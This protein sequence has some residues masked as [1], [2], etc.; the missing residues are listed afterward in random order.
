MY[1]KIIVIGNLGRDPEM[2]YLP[3]GT[4]VCNFNVATS[5]NWTANGEKKS[6]TTWFK[7]AVWG[8]SAEQHHKY[9]NKG[10]KVCVEGEVEV[11]VWTGRD[12]TPAAT[13]VLTAHVVKYLSGKDDGQSG[14]SAPASTHV[15]DDDEESPF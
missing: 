7:V 9:L 6:K 4:A 13:L 8:K 14:S 3:D 12:G 11:E 2:R 15:E 10:S 1:Q 5:K